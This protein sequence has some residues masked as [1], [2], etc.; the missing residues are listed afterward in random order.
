MKKLLVFLT[1]MLLC[2][3]FLASCDSLPPEMQEKID[4]ILDKIGLSGVA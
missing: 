4:P 3:A 1:V 2:L